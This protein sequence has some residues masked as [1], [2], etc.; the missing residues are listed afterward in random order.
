LILKEL[1]D[2]D[3]IGNHDFFFIL[4]NGYNDRQQSLQ[5]IVTSDGVQYDAKMTKEGEDTSWNAVW[6]SAVQIN[7]DSWTA[8]IFIPYSEL[9]FPD[10]EIQ[11]WGLNMERE[12]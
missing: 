9:R 1:T 11:V 12:F 3:Q 4:L 2:R 8:E 7:D 10:K 5:F 6:F